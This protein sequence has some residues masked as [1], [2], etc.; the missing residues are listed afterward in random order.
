VKGTVT[1]S[2]VGRNSRSAAGGRE[3]AA[4]CLFRAGTVP[5]GKAFGDQRE[6]FTLGDA[7]PSDVAS[8]PIW[9]SPKHR[10]VTDHGV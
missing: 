4:L 6:P 3:V 2:A 1:P 7:E 5:P 8:P 10:A 9:L